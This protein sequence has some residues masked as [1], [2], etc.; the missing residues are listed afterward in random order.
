MK[1]KKNNVFSVKPGI[2]GLAQI[3]GIDMSNPEQ[4]ALIDK[5]MISKIN[6]KNYFKY[7]ILTFLGRGFGDKIKKIRNY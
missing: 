2:T 7:L 4:L 5:Y 3:K 1:E 6:Q